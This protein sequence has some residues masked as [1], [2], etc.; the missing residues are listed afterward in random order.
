MVAKKVDEVPEAVGDAALVIAALLVLHFSKLTHGHRE[1]FALSGEE[2][3]D[4]NF[5]A[6]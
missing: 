5:K 3:K 2:A 4:K 1:C 6:F